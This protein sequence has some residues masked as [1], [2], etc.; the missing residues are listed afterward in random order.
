MTCSSRGC[1]FPASVHSSPLLVLA[2]SA[3]FG[4]QSCRSSPV[5]HSQDSIATLTRP[6]LA[7]H[8]DDCVESPVLSSNHGPRGGGDMSVSGLNCTRVSCTLWTPIHLSCPSTQLATSR[9]PR[10]LELTDQEAL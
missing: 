7:Q 1:S 10:S 2:A 9:A 8:H 5:S 3:P 6:G 4:V